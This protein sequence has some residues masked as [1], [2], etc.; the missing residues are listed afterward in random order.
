[1]EKVMHGYE[2]QV[3]DAARVMVKNKIINQKEQL[4]KIRR[5]VKEYQREIKNYSKAL[6]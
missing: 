3:R 1:M 2:K 6:K 4:T 5:S